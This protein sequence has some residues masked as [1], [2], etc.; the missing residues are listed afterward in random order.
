[1]LELIKMEILLLKKQIG[2]I[3]RDLNENKFGSR[4]FRQS[5]TIG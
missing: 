3:K 4:T 1:M 2:Q 5:W